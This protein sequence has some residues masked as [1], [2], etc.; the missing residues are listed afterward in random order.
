[1]GKQNPAANPRVIYCHSRPPPSS[2]PPFP[3]FPR[4]RESTR[5]RAANT[6]GAKRHLTGRGFYIP[7]ILATAGIHRRASGDIIAQAIIAA[8]LLFARSAN[9]LAKQDGKMRLCAGRL[10]R[11][12]IT[13]GFRRRRGFA[14]FGDKSPFALSR[15][16]K[17]GKGMDSRLRGNDGARCAV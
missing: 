17:N 8:F 6:D 14:I 5:C 1:M 15:K 7:V 10:C 12:Q 9:H 4:R 11:P 2:F 13:G 3:S 16:W